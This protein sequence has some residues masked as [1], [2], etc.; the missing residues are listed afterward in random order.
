MGNGLTCLT[1]Q[2]RAIWTMR[3]GYSISRHNPP[4]DVSIL[5]AGSIYR[6]GGKQQPFTPQGQSG[7]KE[8]RT[9]LSIKHERALS[10]RRESHKRM[11]VFASETGQ[12]SSAGVNQDK[13][14][15]MRSASTLLLG[16]LGTNLLLAALSQDVS[17]S[18][19]HTVH[20]GQE[21][22]PRLIA[23]PAQSCIMCLNA[24]SDSNRCFHWSIGRLLACSSLRTVF[25]W[26]LAPN[27]FS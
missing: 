1:S 20:A 11:V 14:L 23:S 27:S 6:Q 25:L 4:A 8:V 2:P 7:P 24:A 5:L 3:S 10:R 12:I 17:Y 9:V 16:A 21:T 18:D 13:T 26:A 22:F 15:W 19:L